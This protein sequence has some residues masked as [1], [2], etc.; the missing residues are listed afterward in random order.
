M[1]ESSHMKIRLGSADTSGD[2]GASTPD[3]ASSPRS[4]ADLTRDHVVAADTERVVGWV[5]ALT[6]A[7]DGRRMHP[8]N[9]SALQ[10][11][12]ADLE[13]ST[14]ACLHQTGDIT[15]RVEEFDLLFEG[16]CVRHSTSL[17]G[18]LSAALFREG[19]RE[20]VIRQGLD[21]DELLAFVDILKCAT[22]GCDPESEDLVTLLWERNFQHI[23]YLCAPL[24][25]WEPEWRA[26]GDEFA[27]G[28]TDAGIPWPTGAQ[29]ER[30]TESGSGSD[31]PDGERS[32]DWSLRAQEAPRVV[33]TPA[34]PPEF[35]E[36]EASNVLM[37]AKIEE[38]ASPRER[39]LE[40]ISAALAEE[41]NPAEY[42]ELASIIGR[43]VEHAVREG[44]MEGARQLV[45]RLRGTSKT[46]TTAPSEFQAAAD[47]ILQDIGRS[48]FLGRLGTTLNRDR[49]VDLSALTSFLAQLGPSAA[50]T[51]C[52][53]LG[54]IGEMNV[55]RA[56][57]D[58]LAISCR[59]DVD[60]LIKRL[61]DPRWFVVR[62]ILYI[63]GRIAHH[64]V[65]RA[66]GDALY[67]SDARVRRESVRAMG[68]IKSPASRAYLNSALRDP[69]K[70]VRILVAAA[71]AERNDERAARIIWGVIESP[72]FA[73]RDA[74]ERL[75]F[76]Q[77][78]GATGSEALVPRIEQMLTRG[79]LFKSANQ[80]GRVEAA[81]ALAWLGTPAALAILSREVKSRNDAVRR[82]VTEALESLRRITPGSRRGGWEGEAPAGEK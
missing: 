20:V 30:E 39:V 64:G 5:D 59:D 77:A 12:H 6:R 24:E 61:S 25:E 34:V 37:V 71:L 60:I 36:I 14:R 22:D 80:D 10:K 43:L 73:D 56:I 2:M 69:D 16:H 29:A 7:I 44:D 72:E 47:Q 51:L 79:G 53:L 41:E 50:P 40:I 32:D 9:D 68:E 81:M 70:T 17:E 54:E 19:L 33:A 31:G 42:L 67:H 74:D 4:K 57:C 52:D 45:E 27:L 48:D 75:A 82:A 49:P 3:K 58:A 38:V 55:R 23:G 18:S 13:A 1:G 26:E 76:F 66:L 8:R 15:I 65:E 46:K 11:L 62:N 35:T 21:S 28:A 63:L 78:L